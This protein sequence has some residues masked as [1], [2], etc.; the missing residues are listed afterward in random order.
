MIAT[1]CYGSP[2]WLAFGSMRQAKSLLSPIITTTAVLPAVS[3]HPITLQVHTHITF[4]TL[5][6]VRSS[7][8]PLYLG[9]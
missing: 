8:S 6:G 3:G 9:K 4:A 5:G 7:M 2:P 1:T